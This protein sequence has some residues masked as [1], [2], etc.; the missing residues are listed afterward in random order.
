MTPS[1]S[2]SSKRKTN[3]KLSTLKGKN[4]LKVAIP[5][6]SIKKE[7]PNI[8][9]SAPMPPPSP[10]D[11]PLLLSGPILTPSS[12]PTRP[13]R[14]REQRSVAVGTSASITH[15]AALELPSPSSFPVDAQVFDWACTDPERSTDFSMMDM[16]QEDA[17]IHRLPLF[18][19]NL[20]D[21]PPSSDADGW[22]DSDDDDDEARYGDHR[23]NGEEVEGE[24]EYT[25]RWNT[26]KVRTKLDPP[27]SATRERME[28]WGRPI[29]PFPKKIAK[30]DLLKEVH[31][32]EEAA[33]GDNDMLGDGD[34]LAE[35]T[36]EEEEREVRGISVPLADEQEDEATIQ[37][38]EKPDIVKQGPFDF[39]LSVEEP[40]VSPEV[41]VVRGDP[42]A[43]HAIPHLAGASP[44]H[45]DAA[46]DG[47]DSDPC[48]GAKVDDWMNDVE[49]A[50]VRQMSVE[51]DDEQDLHAE[52]LDVTFG[53]SESPSLILST[54]TVVDN[55][56]GG[57][58]L[59]TANPSAT[60]EQSCFTGAAASGK[61]T[62]VVAEPQDTRPISKSSEAFVVT[63]TADGDSSDDEF[64]SSFE[65]TGVVEIT[66]ADPR[67]AA[68]AAAILKQVC[69]V[70][71]VSLSPHL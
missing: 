69:L 17:D 41:K 63:E 47:H 16:D 46:I 43:P 25:G 57:I 42:R 20:E 5:A 37:T 50:E 58:H 44:V 61:Y 12:T 10:S 70:L 56:E 11:D 51:L 49:E 35:S 18:V 32:A 39:Y 28:R 59:N 53:E 15:K 65:D 71:L 55:R 13:L 8:D 48:S 31:S 26:V 24:G 38:L 30:L 54:S 29:T 2:K 45:T 1:I 68:R 21:L 52:L 40:V 66:S 36:D 19:L 60:G 6:P 27:S 64:H 67:A 22:S 23:E 4:I 14:E 62:E 33:A 9:L 34:E 7:L 3:V